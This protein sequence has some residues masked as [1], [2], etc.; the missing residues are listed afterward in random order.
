MTQT[1]A[2]LKRV[3]YT[4]QI[5]RPDFVL[6]QTRQTLRELINL[7]GLYTKV[8]PYIHLSLINMSGLT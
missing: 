8:R 6:H 2:I 4:E 1:I 7:S 5:F 3:I